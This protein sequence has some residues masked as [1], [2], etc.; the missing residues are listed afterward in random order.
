MP[1][2]ADPIRTGASG[3][4]STGRDQLR[5]LRAVADREREEAEVVQKDAFFRRVTNRP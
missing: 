5:D 1:M 4:G 2:T 3:R